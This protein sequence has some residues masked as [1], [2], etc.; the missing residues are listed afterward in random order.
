[1]FFLAVFPPARHHS[2]PSEPFSPG[3]DKLSMEAVSKTGL[4]AELDHPFFDCSVGR[5]GGKQPRPLAGGDDH[6]RLSHGKCRH[7]RLLYTV[8]PAVRRRTDGHRPRTKDR[9]QIE[10]QKRHGKS[11]SNYLPL[12]CPILK[13]SKRCNKMRAPCAPSLSL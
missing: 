5:F 3:R 8:P 6:L 13:D 2:V 4:H 10:L 1:M 9:S 11:P 12:V 7:G